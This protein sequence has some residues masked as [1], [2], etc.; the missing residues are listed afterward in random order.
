MT[1]KASLNIY[2]I[3]EAAGVSIATVSRVLSGAENVRPQT[4]QKVLEVVEKTQYT[5]NA[6]ARGLGLGS[7]KM[8]GILCTDVSDSFYARA[9][10]ILEHELRL[11]DFDALLYCTGSDLKDKQRYTSHLLAKH[12]DAIV[13]VGSAFK[14]QIDNSHI[15]FAAKHVPVL[16]INGLVECENTYCILCDEY[17]AMYE[18]VRLLHLHGCKKLAFLY[19]AASYSTVQKIAAYRE[20]VQK[21]GLALNEN[22]IAYCDKTCESAEDVCTDLLNLHPDIDAI[23]TAEDLLAVGACKALSRRG[24]NLP[25]I[26]FDNSAFSV[27]ATPTITSVDNMLG[28]MCAEA[29]NILSTVLAGNKAPHKTILKAK[30]VE[31]ETFRISK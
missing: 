7:M 29:A 17:R 16:I 3:A 27:C 1:E 9:V 18:N 21:Y 8:V 19:H 12:V 28:D 13:L 4:R 31:R 2:D 14:E 30:L 20:A 5:P 25:V 22:L 11:L 6:F 24:M 23:V 10:S 26:G 15:E